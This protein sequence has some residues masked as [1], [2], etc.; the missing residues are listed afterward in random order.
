MDLEAK[1]R[2]F[3]GTWVALAN[4]AASSAE[5]IRLRT[6]RGNGS[7]WQTTGINGGIRLWTFPKRRR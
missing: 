5:K 1:Y 7:R 6:W 2:A 4:R 3:A